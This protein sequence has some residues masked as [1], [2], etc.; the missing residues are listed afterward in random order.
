[1]EQ[2]P[3]HVTLKRAAQTLGVHEQTLR[4]WG[5][6]RLLRLVR[7]PGS[8]Y[9][10]VPVEEIQ[11]LQRE[12]ASSVEDTAVE[13][14]APRADSD[15]LAKASQLGDEIRASMACL[16]AKTSVDEFQARRRGRA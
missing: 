5:R 7:M 9:R 13:L 14:A 11:R 2:A 15:S 16:D 12:M 8:G 1:M 6:P 10:L 4:S 3:T